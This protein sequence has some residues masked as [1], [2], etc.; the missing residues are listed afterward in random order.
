MRI[1]PAIPRNGPVN[2]QTTRVHLAPTKDQN[3]VNSKYTK[4]LKVCVDIKSVLIDV[5]L[6]RG[7][8]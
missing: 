3:M 7:I 4:V 8:M 2:P 1:L 6:C 5:E